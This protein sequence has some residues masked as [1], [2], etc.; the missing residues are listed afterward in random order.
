LK[1]KDYREL[2]EASGFQIAHFEVEGPNSNDLRELDQLPIHEFFSRYTREELG[3]K[4]LFFV[5]E[6]P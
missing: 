2:L 1:A 6:K 4:H 3:A 5:A